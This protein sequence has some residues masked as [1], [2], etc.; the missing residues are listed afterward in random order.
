MNKQEQVK[1]AMTE[2]AKRKPGNKRLVYDKQ[3][4]Q[5][6]ELSNNGEVKPTGLT[7]HDD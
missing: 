2:I 6:V 1:K 4:K 7:M 3:L 5:I